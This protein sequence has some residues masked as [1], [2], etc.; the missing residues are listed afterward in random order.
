MINLKKISTSLILA[1]TVLSCPI[2]L[3]HAMEDEKQH[4]SLLAAIKVEPATQKEDDDPNSKFALHISISTDNSIFSPVPAQ[5]A[6]DT[7]EQLFK[8]HSKFSENTTI[9]AKRDGDRIFCFKKEPEEHLVFMDAEEAQEKLNAILLACKNAPRQEED[10]T[11]AKR[12]AQEAPASDAEKPTARSFEEEKAALQAMLAAQT[13]A[14]LKQQQDQELAILKAQL[15][16]QKAAAEQQAAAAQESLRIQQEAA[17]AQLERMRQEQEAARLKHEQDMLKIQQEAAA[18]AEAQRQAAAR[19][20][21]QRLEAERI[22]REH[23]L[24]QNLAAAVGAP[25]ATAITGNR[26]DARIEKNIKRTFGIKDKKKHKK[27]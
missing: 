16:A 8:T 1:T 14:T 9:E 6:I 20:E 23:Q 11:E 24:Q 22:A 25:L 7:L 18:Q 3:A 21:A 26:S 5:K 13:A 4:T 27:K 17:A 12:I 2:S 19:A 15:A 10:V